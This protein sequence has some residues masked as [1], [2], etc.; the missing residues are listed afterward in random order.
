MKFLFI[1][2]CSLSLPD[3]SGYFLEGE[4]VVFLYFGNVREDAYVSG[5]FNMWCKKD[6]AWKLQF[7]EK[8]KAWKLT[9]PKKEIKALS[10]NF[11]EFTFRVD[12]ILVDADKNNEHV[13]HCVGYGYRYILKGL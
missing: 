6:D 3:S 12:G 8:M 5:N 7:D 4:N 2:L 1:L 9:V 11:Y 10:G 13:I